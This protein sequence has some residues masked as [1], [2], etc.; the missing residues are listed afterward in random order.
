MGVFE[1]LTLAV[2]GAWASGINLYAT[3]L[4]FGLLNAFGV[5][6]LPPELEVLGSWWMISI[7]GTMY[8]VEFVADKIPG[9]DSVWDII[10]SFIRI[11][12]GAAIAAGAVGGFSGGLG[13]DVGSVLALLAGGT[14]AAGSHV[15]KAGTRAVINTSPEPFTNWAASVTEDV[16]VVGGLIFAVIQ[17]IVFVIGLIIFVL[18]AIWLMPKIWR[19]IKR[20][21]GG[22]RH[23]VDAARQARAGPIVLEGADKGLPPPD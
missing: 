23:P 13:G 20:V 14:V 7:A 12:A 10:H 18:L 22:V 4:T 21:F 5:I 6:D 2:G 16:A 8:L 1:T 19:G 11:P 17:P 3:A 15:T 9:V